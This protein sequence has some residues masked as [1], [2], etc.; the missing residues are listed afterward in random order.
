MLLLPSGR[1]HNRSLSHRRHGSAEPVMA[2][3][4]AWEPRFMLRRGVPSALVSAFLCCLACGKR[5][6]K[7]AAI[8][9]ERARPMPEPDDGSLG[10]CAR[11]AGILRDEGTDDL[12]IPFLGVF[13]I[14]NGVQREIVPL[15]GRD[16]VWLSLRAAYSLN[17]ASTRRCA[18]GTE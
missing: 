17:S 2:A 18:Q 3:N 7:L 8:T 16:P 15:L 4:A 9:L 14:Q 11:T 13:D 12:A 1:E 10:D 6:S 5:Q